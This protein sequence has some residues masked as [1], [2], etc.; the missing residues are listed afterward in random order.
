MRISDWSS[1]VCSSDLGVGSLVGHRTSGV[2]SGVAGGGGGVGGRVGSV[3]CNVGGHAAGSGSFVG[4]GLRGGSGVG[5]VGSRIH[6]LLLVAACSQGETHG[7]GEQRLVDRHV[8][9]PRRYKMVGN[10]RSRTRH[11]HDKTASTVKRCDTF[12]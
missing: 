3:L 7:Q 2:G 11:Q 1:D 8:N 9:L 10:A 12:Y 4:G 5:G 6:G